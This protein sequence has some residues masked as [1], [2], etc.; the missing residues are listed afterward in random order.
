MKN[1]VTQF[2]S[3]AAGVTVVLLSTLVF[4]PHAEAGRIVVNN[5][6]WTLSN[7]GFANA[8]DAGTFATNIADWFT[9]GDLGTF[10]AHS[11]N[12]GL[13]ESSLANAI[14]GAGHTWTTGLLPIF[15]L[16]ALLQFDGIFLGGDIVDNQVLIDYVNAGGNV[17]LMG[18]AG[19]GGSAVVEAQSWNPFLNEFG[20]GLSSPYNAV[21]GNVNIASS[22]PIFQGVDT[23]YQDLGNPIVDLDLNDPTAEILVDHPSGGLY[24]VYKMEAV[25]VP[26][27]SSLLGLLAFS[28]L[29][30]GSRL[31]RKQ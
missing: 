24:A 8:P 14:G 23:L 28:A 27:P 31:K 2:V 5:D 20:L 29:G 12:F 21:I 16:P 6:E 25:D 1:S 4:S 3:T 19:V 26:E 17:Y 7:T 22:H 18:G 9:D 30:I 10:H 11:T 15:D 13:T